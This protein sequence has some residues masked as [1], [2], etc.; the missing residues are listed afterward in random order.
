MGVSAVSE[1][2]YPDSIKSRILTSCHLM[3]AGLV[4]PVPDI[5]TAGLVYPVPD[6][7]P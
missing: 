2:P 6:I 1:R 5:M 4:Y 3:T 7:I